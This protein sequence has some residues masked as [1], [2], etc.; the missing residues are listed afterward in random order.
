MF[1]IPSRGPRSRVGCTLLIAAALAAV[2][3]PGLRAQELVEVQLAENPEFPD[4]R[5]EKVMEVGSV[6]GSEETTFGWVSSL[7]FTLDHQLWVVDSDPVV[8]RFGLDGE[9]LGQSGRRGE[10]PGEYKQILGLGR[11]GTEMLVFDPSQ[12]RI[13]T[14]GSSGEF[15]TSVNLPLASSLFG[16]GVFH[17]DRS[18]RPYVK[19]ILW[20]QF[21]QSDDDVVDPTYAWIGAS[22]GMETWDT[23]R[24]G[25]PDGVVTLH[26][27]EYA[28]SLYQHNVEVR[29]G[30]S[31][32]IITSDARNFALSGVINAS[33]EKVRLSKPYQAI[34]V[35]AEERAMWERSKQRFGSRVASLQIP[36][37]K[38]AFRDFR[39]DESGRIWIS[40][41]VEAE[42]RTGVLSLSGREVEERRFLEPPIWEVY[43]AEGRFLVRLRFPD[44]TRFYGARDEWVWGVRYGVYGEAYPTVMKIVGMGN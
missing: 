40:R 41:H 8:R 7:S 42:W 10:G 37:H 26:F 22:R 16:E 5:L 32:E 6:D 17:A 18:G 29:L 14:L 21:P 44:N 27:T 1:R 43:T 28:E 31:G 34:K 25:E 13:S 2:S 11:S 9:F 4:A 33:G 39:I 3:L 12:K 24:T 38:P 23:L 36:R 15:I 19:T 35:S 20:D 30:T